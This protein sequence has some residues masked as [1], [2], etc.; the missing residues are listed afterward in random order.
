[1]F[2]HVVGERSDAGARVPRDRCYMIDFSGLADIRAA[3]ETLVGAAVV[4]V[5]L[6]AGVAL[7]IGMTFQVSDPRR[8]PSQFVDPLRGALRTW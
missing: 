7:T 6:V 2:P 8:T 4:A 1:M 3:I 5:A